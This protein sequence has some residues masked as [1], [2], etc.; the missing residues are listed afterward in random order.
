MNNTK[1]ELKQRE[2]LV[3]LVQEA[4]FREKEELEEKNGAKEELI[5]REVAAAKGLVPLMDQIEALRDEREKID[6]KIRTLDSKIGIHGFSRNSAGKLEYQHYNAP[7]AIRALIANKLAEARRP[8]EKSL[9]KY[10]IAISK[11]WSVTTG[12]ELQK[13]VEGLF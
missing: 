12:E 4:R 10:D 11:I 3:S 6:D 1:I 13:A 5:R 9:K 7:Q 8:I 2:H